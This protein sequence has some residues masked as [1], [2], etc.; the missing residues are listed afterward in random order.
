MTRHVQTVM[1]LTSCLLRHVTRKYAWHDMTLRVSH[2]MSHI[3]TSHVTHVNDMCGMTY[4]CVWH[5][6]LICVTRLIGISDMTHWYVWHDSWIHVWYDMTWQNIEVF[7][8]MSRVN[9]LC[10]EP[11]RSKKDMAVYRWLVCYAWHF[12][13]ICDTLTC[14]TW[15]DRLEV[16]HIMAHTFAL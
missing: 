11:S 12:W 6:S 15:H 5:D 9:D 8:F 10:H 16:C 2:V 1:A 13:L 7:Y 3:S 4:S 14:V